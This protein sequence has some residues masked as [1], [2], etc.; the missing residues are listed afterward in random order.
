MAMGTATVTAA[1]SRRPRPSTSRT[2]ISLRAFGGGAKLKTG[3]LEVPVQAT[4]GLLAGYPLAIDDKF[5]LEF[6]AGFT[7]TPV[8]YDSMG[9][10]K[11]ASLIAAARRRRCD[12][13]RS[14]PR[15]ACAAISGSAR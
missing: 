3:D 10:S 2:V 14:R 6:G 12:V 4:F 1:I 7:F 9:T 13:T 8:P 5:V 15:S 11:N